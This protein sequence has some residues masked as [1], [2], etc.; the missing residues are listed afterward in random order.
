M[1]LPKTTPLTLCL[2]WSGHTSLILLPQD[3]TIV[4]KNGGISFGSGLSF[5][6]KAK[7]NYGIR[8]FLDYNLQPSH[9]KHSGEWMNTLAVGTSFGVNF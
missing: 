8:F 5:S 4:E 9:S 2:R 1:K 6:Y 7:E 3:G